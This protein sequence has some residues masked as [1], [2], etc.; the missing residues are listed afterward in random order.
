MKLLV[1]FFGAM[2]DV[3]HKAGVMASATAL[4]RIIDMKSFQP[5]SAVDIIEKLCSLKDDF[6]R[7]VASTRLGVYKLLKSLITSS[8]VQRDLVKRQSP[9]FE[10]MAQLIELCRNERDPDCLMVWFDIQTTFL[11]QFNPTP[12][13]LEEVYGAFKAYYPITL[14]RTAKSTITP[15]ELKSRLRACFSCNSNLAKH[16][17]PFLVGKLDQGDGVTVNVK[18]DVLKTI[19]ACIEQYDDPKESV[20]PYAN[21]IWGSLKYEVRNGEIEDTIWATLEVLKALTTR[22]DG[23]DLRDYILNVTRDCVGDLA[24]AMY[25]GPAG[26]LLISVLSASPVAFVLMVAP[27]VT[28]IKENLRHPKSLTHSQDLFKLLGVVLQTRLLLM[29]LHID[30]ET[31][32][33]FAAVD[34]AF[35][36]LYHDVFKSTLEKGVVPNPSDEDVKITTAAVHGAAILVCQKPTLTTMAAAGA[37]TETKSL[38]S[39]ETCSEICNSLYSIISNYYGPHGGLTPGT[40]EMVNKTTEALQRAIVAYPEGF[41]PLVMQYQN[42][43]VSQRASS[44]EDRVELIQGFGSALAF[45]GCSEFPKSSKYGTFQFLCLSGAFIPELLLAIQNGSDP[46]IWCAAIASI[47]SVFRYFSDTLTKMEAKRDQIYNGAESKFADEYASWLEAMAK[48]KGLLGMADGLGSTDYSELAADLPDS[49]TQA[50]KVYLNIGYELIKTLYQLSTSGQQ[51][52]SLTS[53]YTGQNGRFEHQY[54]HLLSGFGG[55]LIHELSEAQQLDMLFSKRALDLFHEGELNIETVQSW[56][57]LINSRVNTLMFGILEA[58]R[59]A[60][61]TQ[62]VSLDAL[63]KICLCFIN[64]EK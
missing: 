43:L 29:D 50:H 61:V 39:N 37:E 48:Y 58:A 41:Q 30:E 35:T 4:S 18:I 31:Q 7:Q 42:L 17:F 2:F 6:P 46:K 33:D 16:T 14:P 10:F 27:T 52:L 49:P 15:E 36:S 22:L 28:H 5:S 63:A 40:D 62:I 26:R 32:K 59:P 44:T 54:L 8:E 55:F 34:S 53:Q 57:W 13:L 24:S 21:R 51:E 60:V 64:S 9:S 25:C 12:E 23:D 19:H 1:A 11:T 20:V 38:L 56:N 47:Q 45:I 3:D